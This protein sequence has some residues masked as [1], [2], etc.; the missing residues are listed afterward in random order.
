MS[1]EGALSLL[2][3]TDQGWLEWEV[4]KTKTPDGLPSK[5]FKELGTFLDV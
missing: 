5:I 4:M 1:L 3:A 2:G